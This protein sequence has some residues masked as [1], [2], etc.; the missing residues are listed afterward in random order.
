MWSLERYRCTWSYKTVKGNLFPILMDNA[1][2]RSSWKSLYDQFLNRISRPSTSTFK[3]TKIIFYK[4]WNDN[5]WILFI[6]SSVSYETV[7]QF[8]LTWLSYENI[9]FNYLKRQ[10]DT[11]VFVN[12]INDKISVL[13]I[14]CTS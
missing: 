4:C 1:I 11:F 6:T 12:M 7:S 14:A 13:K 2:D 8:L 9:Q 10:E 3:E 5:W